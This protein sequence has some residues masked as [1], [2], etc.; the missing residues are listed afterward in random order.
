MSEHESV[1]QQIARFE[2]QKSRL[3]HNLLE[4][5][6]REFAQTLPPSERRGA[7]LERANK[8]RAAIDEAIAFIDLDIERLR[9]G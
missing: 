8:I 3:S 7:I 5:W 2:R 4:D 1:E 6:L 9:N